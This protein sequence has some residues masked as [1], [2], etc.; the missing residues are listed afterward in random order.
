MFDW[1]KSLF[2]T[3][4][5]YKIQ[6]LKKK[7]VGVTAR[8]L[9]EL[10]KKGCEIFKIN[11]N[12]LS[13]VL[14]NDGTSVN[15][16]SY[17]SK[18]PEQTSFIFLKAGETWNGLYDLISE[19]LAKSDST[20]LSNDERNRLRSFLL[21]HET[22]EKCKQIQESVKEEECNVRAETNTDHETWFNGIKSYKTKSDYMK[23]R[24]QNRIRSYYM[25]AK[26][27]IE[28]TTNLENKDDLLDLLNELSQELSNNQFHGGY[29]ARTDASERIC[30][31]MGWFFCEGQF[32]QN[33]CEKQHKIN[34][35]ISH[36][37]RVMFSLWEL[38]H[39]IE[40]SRVV[41]PT[42]LE[43]AKRK[44]DTQKLSWQKVYDLLF[45]RKNLKLVQKACHDKAARENTLEW[46]TFLIDYPS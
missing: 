19:V 35:Y 37:H 24:A 22:M 2:A 12:E 29:F 44:D 40:K 5:P 34:P 45:T 21:E 13:I 46:R 11:P 16:Q 27:R 39:I 31:E 33:V 18:L 26:K 6:N 1:L 10:T 15:T 30:D 14:E 36:T 20:I 42:L 17:F 7:R 25:N 41:I 4:R 8:N 23:N 9:E 38:D 28:E 3:K 32:N 43:A